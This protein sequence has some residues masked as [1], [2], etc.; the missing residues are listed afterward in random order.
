G[1]KVPRDIEAE[2]AARYGD[3]QEIIAKFK[4]GEDIA[5]LSNYPLIVGTY[6]SPSPY[7]FKEAEQIAERL[8]DA[9]C[10]EVMAIG[11]FTLTKFSLSRRTTPNSFRLAVTLLNRWRQDM[12]DFIN[13]LAFSI[14]YGISKK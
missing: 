14:L 5:N 6:L 11:N 10:G 13:R 9:P 4:E 8:W 7:N 1:L 3:I 2:A 12:T